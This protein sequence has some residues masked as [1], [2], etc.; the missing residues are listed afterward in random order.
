LC[1]AGDAPWSMRFYE[2]LL[3][4]S[5]PIVEKIQ[6]TGRNDL[7]Y[8]IGYKYYL[9]GDDKMIYRPDWAEENFNKFIRYQTLINDES[10]LLPES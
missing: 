10:G 4:R 6:H 8:A 2:S 9:L 1:P 5:I 3:C 7:E